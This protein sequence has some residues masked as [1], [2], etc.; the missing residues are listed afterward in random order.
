MNHKRFIKFFSSQKTS[1]LAN[2]HTIYDFFKSYFANTIIDTYRGLNFDKL[3]MQVIKH[4]I[5]VTLQYCVVTVVGNF[6]WHN[7]KTP[8]FAK[9]A[10]L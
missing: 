9:N 8:N 1:A 5:I 3:I 7:F 6:W 2:L 10:Q 4:E